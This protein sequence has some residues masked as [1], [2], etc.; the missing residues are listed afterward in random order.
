MIPESRIKNYLLVQCN[1]WK[2][3]QYWTVDD[4]DDDDDDEMLMTRNDEYNSGDVDG[5]AALIL[6][7]SADQFPTLASETSL[8][9]S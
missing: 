2:N 1:T 3:I 6:L 8:S 4:E 9:W 5:G 7:R